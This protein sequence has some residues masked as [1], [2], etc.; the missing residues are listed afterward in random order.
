VGDK[1]TVYYTMM[2]TQIE[3]KAGTAAAKPPAA[4]PTKPASPKK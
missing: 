2:A 3:A 4:A 1:V